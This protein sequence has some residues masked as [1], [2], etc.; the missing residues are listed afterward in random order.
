MYLL[1]HPQKHASEDPTSQD[2]EMIRKRDLFRAEIAASEHRL[3][4]EHAVLGEKLLGHIVEH[5]VVSRVDQKSERAI[6]AGRAEIILIEMR[7]AASLD[8]D[9]AFD[10]SLRLVHRNLVIGFLDV[11]EFFVERSRRV[12]PALDALRK[13]HE[14]SALVHRDV[15]D[16]IE[17]PEGL[18]R[19]EFGEVGEPRKTRFF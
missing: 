10:A 3:A 8:A 16:E 14:P 17:I 12:N 11:F 9:S 15:F 18:D 6:E 2:S 19:D 7:R 5:P 4:A 1:F 13:S